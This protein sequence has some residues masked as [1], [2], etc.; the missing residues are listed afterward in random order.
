MLGMRRIGSVKPP[1]AAAKSHKDFGGRKSP[2]Q[3][4]IQSQPLRAARVAF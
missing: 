2:P 3:R 1:N 4:M